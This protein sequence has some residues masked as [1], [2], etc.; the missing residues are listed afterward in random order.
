MT[1]GIALFLIALIGGS[2]LLAL[3][4]GVIKGLLEPFISN[5]VHQQK[6]QN[7]V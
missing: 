2:I 3:Y 1:K 5:A 7:K 6:N 4:Q